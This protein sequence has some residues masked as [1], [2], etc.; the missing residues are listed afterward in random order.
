M[1]TYN[2]ILAL[3]FVAI[4]TSLVIVLPT[5]NAANVVGPNYKN[6]TVRT[7]VNITNSK[8]QVLGV[9]VFETLN[10]SS[11][12]V[13]VS[14]GSTK[15]VTCNAS[16]RDWNG[17]NDIVHVNAT[18][19]YFLNQSSDSDDTNTHYTNASCTVND[20][21]GTY[22]GYFTCVFDVFYYANNG[23]WVCNVTVK[24]TYVN[25]NFTGYN[26]NTTYFYPVYAL[27]VTD[28][29]DYGNVAVEEYSTPDKVA[30]ITN[31]GNRAINVSVEGYGIRRGD[32]LAMNCSI[33]GNITIDNERFATNA[34]I[35]YGNKASLTNASAF[36]PGLTMPKQTDPNALIINSTYWQLYIPPNPAG[37]CTGYVIFTAMAP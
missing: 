24:D 21:T 7:F 10:V 36:I 31:F 13:T 27:N 32:G 18:L 4:I 1:K 2:I 19:Y 15:S 12:N 30:N 22:T 6:V 29:I 37:N 33:F 16:V 20:S 5:S 26:S 8:P 11:R 14:A 23:T 35:A 3:L 28:G 9:S 34:S 25:P 17:F